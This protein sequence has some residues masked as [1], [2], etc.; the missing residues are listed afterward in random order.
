MGKGFDIGGL[1]KQAQ[2]LQERLSSV[3]EEIRTRT[4]EG[5]A[6]GGMVTAIVNGKL[7]V[8]SVH[9]DPSLLAT[10]DVEMLQDLVVAAV[11]GGIR[12]A[13]QMMAEEMSKVTGGLKIPG[14]G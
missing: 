14:L 2:Q 8:M 1:L 7:E 11:N 4:A 3:Q 10:P 9:I 5:S 6:G 12:A 13:Q